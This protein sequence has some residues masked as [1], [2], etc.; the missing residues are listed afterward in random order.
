MK[1]KGFLKPFYPLQI[2][3]PPWH[4]CGQ[5]GQN[6]CL[7]SESI[8]L[9]RTYRLHF[10]IGKGPHLR[11]KGQGLGPGG[12][13]RTGRRPPW[14]PWGALC[15]PARA[16]CPWPS[17]SCA[18]GV[19][20][21]L[22]HCEACRPPSSSAGTPVQHHK[23]RSAPTLHAVLSKMSLPT[24]GPGRPEITPFWTTWVEYTAT[25]LCHLSFTEGPLSCGKEQR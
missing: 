3:E 5:A 23:A 8:Q 13:G 11:H 4:S 25:A 6:N 9:L 16:Q 17:C 24:R 2:A 19:L 21:P 7:Q 18:C 10:A 15:A 14:D 1:S 22:A 12:Q 20:H